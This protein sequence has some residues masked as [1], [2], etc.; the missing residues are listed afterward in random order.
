MYV[1][2][3]K[4]NITSEVGKLPLALIDLIVSYDW[5]DRMQLLATLVEARE[6]EIVLHPV[7]V[8]VR[9]EVAERRVCNANLE[10]REM[11]VLKGNISV[12][13]ARHSKQSRCHHVSRGLDEFWHDVQNCRLTK[14][15]V[16][17]RMGYYSFEADLK[18][19]ITE[20]NAQHCG[21]I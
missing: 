10:R 12:R 19:V 18:R 8:I 20:K 4:D 5:D 21:D 7:T 6:M 13:T 11:F 17:C 9:V 16:F 15:R 1:A 3:R 2:R 14:A